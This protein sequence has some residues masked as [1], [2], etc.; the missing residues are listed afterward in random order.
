MLESDPCRED[1]HRLIM[2]CHAGLGHTY[3]AFQQYE[4]CRRVLRAALD[5]EPSPETVA[6]YE[7]IRDGSPP[8][9]PTSG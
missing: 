4:S 2:S 3:Q 9:L 5:T 8:D 7:R 6:L 1:A